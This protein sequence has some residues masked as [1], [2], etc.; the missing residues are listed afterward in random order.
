M[1]VFIGLDIGG[2]K[3]LVAS[4]NKEGTIIKKQLKLTPYLHEEG[5]SLLNRMIYDVSGGKGI[6]AIGAAIGGPID[7]QSGVVSPLHQETWRNIPLK[8]I[9]QSKWNCP[10]YV[11]N[12]TNVAA[13]GEYQSIDTKVSKLVYLT[14]STGVGAGYIVD[15]KIYRGANGLHPEVGHQSINYECNKINNIT[16]KCG[17]KNCLEVFISGSGIKTIYGKSAENLDDDEWTEVSYNLGQGLRNISVFYSPDLIILGGG[18]AIGRGQSL[19]DQ[20]L[21]TIN[22]EVHIIPTPEVRLSNLGN[23]ATLI[24]AIKL[25][26]NN[27]CMF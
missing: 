21:R 22:S 20:A 3:F 12:D 13:L 17:A 11:D 19:L 18:V 9:M 25:A 16:C 8:E 1:S 15:G 4:A 26:I 6:S 27:E 23:E 14:I 10:F 24:G 2:T 5:L 7:W